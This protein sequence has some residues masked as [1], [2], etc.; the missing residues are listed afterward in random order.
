MPSRHSLSIFM[1]SA[2]SFVFALA[3]TSFAQVV[4]PQL[5]L[6]P[7]GSSLRKVAGIPA[8]AAV[9]APVTFSRNLSLVNASS[10]GFAVASDADS[11]LVLIV[12]PDTSATTLSNVPLKPDLIQLSPRGSAALLWYMA[13]RHAQI[14]SGLPSNPT[15]RDLDLSFIAAKPTAL[16]VSDDGLTVAVAWPGIVYEFTAAGT[17]GLPINGDSAALAF[18]P[19]TSDL[20]IASS[21]TA[22]LWNN[23]GITNLASFPNPLNPVA[24]GLDSRRL[25][26]A[27]SSG[28]VVTVDLASGS[29]SSIDCQCTPAGLYPLNQSAYR[30][31][32]LSQGAFKILDTNQNA[33]WFAPLALSATMGGQQ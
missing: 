24:A 9:G 21:T 32:G 6:I 2:V 10:Q 30:L 13:G 20:A 15:A 3:S 26:I 11:G 12:A 16:A 14:L 22:T 5:G 19:G 8:A 18:S 25:V 7:D 33:I 29:Q 27:D 23:A 17:A 31:T 1:K 4:G 28:A